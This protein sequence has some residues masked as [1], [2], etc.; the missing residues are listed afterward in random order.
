[1]LFSTSVKFF[2]DILRTN[3][4]I[5]VRN[6]FLPYFQRAF[7]IL[8]LLHFSV[9]IFLILLVKKPVRL[10]CT[11]KDITGEKIGFSK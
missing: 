8:M 9:L 1:M 3:L 4:V 2:K 6:F 10:V 5:F 11:G 7:H